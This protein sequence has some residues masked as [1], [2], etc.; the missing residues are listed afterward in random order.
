VRQ[1]RSTV[2]RLPSIAALLREDA[3]GV[4]GDGLQ[5]IGEVGRGGCA[6]EAPPSESLPSGPVERPHCPFAGEKRNLAMF[7][8]FHSGQDS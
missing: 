2:Y 1:L 4:I 3:E 7:T 5:Q 6:G 8:E